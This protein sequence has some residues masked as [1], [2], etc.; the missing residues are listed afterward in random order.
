MVEAFSQMERSASDSFFTRSAQRKSSSCNVKPVMELLNTK[1]K[2]SQRN[3]NVCDFIFKHPKSGK[4]PNCQSFLSL[5]LCI[6]LILTW[7]STFAFF[8]K[9]C[10]LVLRKSLS[11]VLSKGQELL[12][13]PSQGFMFLYILEFS[14]LC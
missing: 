3:A 10:T 9:L 1:S 14:C 11:R 12:L 6:N 2:K 7:L 13:K 5:S 4:I 8:E